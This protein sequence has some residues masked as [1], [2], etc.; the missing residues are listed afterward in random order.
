MSFIRS[1]FKRSNVKTFAKE[2]R[3]EP[4]NDKK[5]EDTLKIALHVYQLIDEKVH[6][7]YTIK[8]QIP[9]HNKECDL[10]TDATAKNKIVNSIIQGEID[11][12]NTEEICNT[13][14]VARES[15]IM[16]NGGLPRWIKKNKTEELITNDQLEMIEQENP[17]TSDPKV[18]YVNSSL[19]S[20][21][22][23]IFEF[24]VKLGDVRTAMVLL[25]SETNDLLI[26]LAQFKTNFMSFPG[27]EKP[28]PVK[29]ND[30]VEVKRR[31]GDM[32][33]FT[34]GLYKVESLDGDVAPLTF[35]QSLDLETSEVSDNPLNISPEFAH[36]FFN[37]LLVL[38]EGHGLPLEKI[39]ADYELIYQIAWPEF[40]R[41]IYDTESIQGYKL[42]KEYRTSPY[43]MVVDIADLA[44]LELGY[45]KS[46]RDL[47][48]G[49]LKLLYE[50][51]GYKLARVIYDKAPDD[52]PIKQAD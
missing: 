51:A 2:I 22:G 6:D 40:S 35:L 36:D 4:S 7:N 49:E 37:T 9:S 44:Y 3:Q 45:N 21:S 48:D 32:S 20:S 50:L 46:F 38:S 34:T 5:R 28:T 19:I 18:L 14:M 42:A 43:Q 16:E 25:N 15:L 13:Y 8:I 39:A 29:L 41:N 26:H 24:E 10:N 47:N 11:I 23:D 12:N 33:V 1:L 52:H 17:K 31:L 30:I 27:F